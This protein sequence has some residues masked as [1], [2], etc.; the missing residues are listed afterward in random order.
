MTVGDWFVN[1][2]G[3]ALTDIRQ[4]LV[5]EPWFGRRVTPPISAERPSSLAEALGWATS[6]DERDL[7]DDDARSREPDRAPT[8]RGH[9]LD[10]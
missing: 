5:E 8:G 6:A 4:K 3:T 10:R 2:F 1:G 7:R 9:E